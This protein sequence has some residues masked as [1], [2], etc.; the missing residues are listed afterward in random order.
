MRRRSSALQHA[1]DARAL[2]KAVKQSDPQAMDGFGHVT[3]DAQTLADRKHVIFYRDEGGLQATN[4]RNIPM[5]V[6]YYLGV[7]D[8]CTPFSLV[9]RLEHFWKGLKQDKHAI[10]AVP[11]PEY[12]ERFLNFLLSVMPGADQKLRPKG[13]RPDEIAPMGPEDETTTHEHVGSA[14]DPKA[15]YKGE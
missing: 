2:R 13:L 6:I 8:I 9:K 12:G 7:I 5:D 1:A 10:S 4:D 15:R 11:P 14:P 3:L